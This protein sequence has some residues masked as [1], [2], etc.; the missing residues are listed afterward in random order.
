MPLFS[1]SWHAK[2]PE[3]WDCDEAWKRRHSFRPA[4]AISGAWNS[5]RS[6]HLSPLARRYA[7]Q[8]CYWRRFGEAP[9]LG[10]SCPHNHFAMGLGRCSRLVHVLTLR[11]TWRAFFVLS[12]NFWVSSAFSGGQKQRVAMARVFYHLP[13]YGILDECTSAVSVEVEGKIYTTCARLGITLFT[14]SHRASLRTCLH[15]L[16][17]DAVFIWVGKYH[18][19]ELHFNGTGGW[20]WSKVDQEEST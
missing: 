1:F 4:E 18:D 8:W 10:R 6:N 3:Q 2:A 20:S 13:L 5:S 17:V 9:S 15:L 19:Y 12:S 7:K 14:V 16:V 11:L